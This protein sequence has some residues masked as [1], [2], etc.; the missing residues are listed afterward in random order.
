M[1]ANCRTRLNPALG[2]GRID[3]IQ[4][5]IRQDLKQTK[6]QRIDP[7]RLVVRSDFGV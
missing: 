3:L 2:E 4:R 7:R 6:P 5:Q 1:G